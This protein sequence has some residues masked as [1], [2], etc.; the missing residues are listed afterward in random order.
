MIKRRRMKS[1]E[2]IKLFSA[3]CQRKFTRQRKHVQRER[4]REK[5]EQKKEK[6]KKKREEMNF[7]DHLSPS[8]IQ[9]HDTVI[10]DSKGH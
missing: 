10:K 4:E 6:K 5:N 3:S 8:I 2:E 7:Y 9:D 1:K